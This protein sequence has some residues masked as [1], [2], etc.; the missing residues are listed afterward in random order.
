MHD[1]RFPSPASNF[2]E[3][4]LSIR[5]NFKQE[6]ATTVVSSLGAK[7]SYGDAAASL[8]RTLRH[9][10]EKVSLI[11]VGGYHIGMA[12]DEEESIR[13]V[14]TALDNGVNFLGNCRDY[15][16]GVSEVRIGK[17]LRGGCL[18]GLSS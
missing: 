7:L 3:D 9:T 12:S 18:K 10:G 2:E 15:N 8:H 17:A 16:G 4:H 1:V 14:R 5:E 11:G 6:T 13:I